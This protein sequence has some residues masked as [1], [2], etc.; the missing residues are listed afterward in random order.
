MHGQHDLISENA[1]KPPS[2][3]PE[4]V[5]SSVVRRKETGCG[6]DG[7]RL[8]KNRGRSGAGDAGRHHRDDSTSGGGG[9][10][11]RDGVGAG[12][13]G[14]TAA[15]AGDCSRVHISAATHSNKTPLKGAR[16]VWGTLRSTTTGAIT[17]ALKLIPE[18]SPGSVTVKRKYKT[19][20]GKGHNEGHVTKWWF[21]LRGEE[22]M[23]QLLE[24][25]WSVIA[26]QTAW[27]LEPVVLPMCH[28]H[29]HRLSFHTSLRA[30]L[31][32]TTSPSYLARKLQTL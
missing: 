10:G 21:I 28:L 3:F 16:K 27:K 1:T 26:M 12:G 20:K 11:L 8:R 4:T 31:I 9:G 7:R 30:V 14:G 29:L 23:L 18:I 25:K 22:E 13:M 24:R 5:A 6:E 15:V 32:I 17:N 2:T 19:L